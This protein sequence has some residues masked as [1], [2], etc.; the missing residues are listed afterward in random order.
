MQPHTNTVVLWLSHLELSKGVG[1][2]T[3]AEWVPTGVPVRRSAGDRH[4]HTTV[5]TPSHETAVKG[6]EVPRRRDICILNVVQ[7][8]KGGVASSP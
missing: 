8:S 4:T 3:H 6:A 7:T 1:V 5:T 2:L